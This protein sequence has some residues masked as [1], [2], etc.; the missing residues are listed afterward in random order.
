L[1]EKESGPVQEYD[2][3]VTV[4]AVRLSGFPEHTIG[5]LFPAVGVTGVEFT[6]ATVFCNCEVHPFKVAETE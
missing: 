4:V 2:A 3:P 5:P 1:A 6:V